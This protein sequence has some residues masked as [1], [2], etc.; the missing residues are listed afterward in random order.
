MKDKILKIGTW[1]VCEMKIQQVQKLSM[2]YNDGTADMTVSDGYCSLSSAKI[3]YF[4][5]TLNTKIIS[6]IFDKEY[7]KLHDEVDTLN[8]NWPEIH[9]TFICI[10]EEA[11]NALVND[12]WPA[13]D[14]MKIIYNKMY[15]FSDSIRK[16]VANCKAKKVVVG[17]FSVSLFRN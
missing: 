5:L 2:E 8:I 17:A 4:P 16:E 7:Q 10:W 11:C 12:A 14:V 6:E 15:S 1:I 3:Y 13:N 9:D